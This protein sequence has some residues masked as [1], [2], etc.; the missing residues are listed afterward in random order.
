MTVKPRLR[1][2]VTAETTGADRNA[3]AQTEG[4][5]AAPV[6]G[7]RFRALRKRYLIAHEGPS[8][9]N[10]KGMRSGLPVPNNHG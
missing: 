6:A 9:L 5:I 8:S 10:L 3:D 2:I 4:D 7:L 1:S